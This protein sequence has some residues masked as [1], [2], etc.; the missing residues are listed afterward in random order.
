M[1]VCRAVDTAFTLLLK[2]TQHFPSAAKLV[3]L[4]FMHGKVPS[5][6]SVECS[7]LERIKSYPLVTYHVIA[8]MQMLRLETSCQ[9]ACDS[10][11]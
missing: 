1:T 8:V 4:Q 9:A 7:W 2:H 5:Y 3:R 6:A 10:Y 11:G